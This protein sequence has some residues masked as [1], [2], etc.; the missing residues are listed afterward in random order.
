[1][2]VPW[3]SFIGVGAIGGVTGF[4]A[5]FLPHGLEGRMP[6]QLRVHIPE[7]SLADITYHIV[8][9]IAYGGL[10]SILGWLAYGSSADPNALSGGPVNARVFVASAILGLTGTS[11]VNSLVARQN[12]DRTIQN[13]N[14]A[15]AQ[16]TQLQQEGAP[17]EAQ[18]PPGQQP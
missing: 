13:L 15:V 6:E 10:A 14:A 18:E 4:L 5:S 3:L 1:M 12:Q 2:A 8:Q 9:N 7:A 16:L 17:A 11:V